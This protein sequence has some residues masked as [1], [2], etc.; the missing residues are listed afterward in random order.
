[1]TEQDKL[2]LINLWNNRVPTTKIIQLLPYTQYAIRNMIKSL[3]YNGTLIEDNRIP[4]KCDRIV[5]MYY[6]GVKDLAELAEMFQCTRQFVSMS[7]RAKGIYTEKPKKYKPHR[8]T[9][10]KQAII[11]GLKDGKTQTEVAKSNG[12]SRQYVFK[13]YNQYVKEK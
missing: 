10:R 7:L 2:T 6:S 9:G 8:M 11:D 13:I 12:V 5:S 4:P 1:M 3:I